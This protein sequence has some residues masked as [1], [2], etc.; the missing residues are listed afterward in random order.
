MNSL[1]DIFIQEDNLSIDNPEITN[2]TNLCL[3]N[4]PFLLKF[5]LRVEEITSE[6]NNN[7][8]QDLL[9]NHSSLLL[10]ELGKNKFNT[11]NLE[12]RMKNYVSINLKDNYDRLSTLNECQVLFMG[13]G[14][15]GKTSTIRSLFD[16]SFL[17]EDNSTL[18]L[19]D[20]DIFSVHPDSY[21]WNSISKYELSVQR[22]KNSLPHVVYVDFDPNQEVEA[23]YKLDFEEELLS[24]TVCDEKFIESMKKI[25]MVLLRMMFIFVFMIL[26]GKKYFLLFIIFL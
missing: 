12:G 2:L 16:K 11:K 9:D 21:N 25:V 26:V 10:F 3:K 6:E 8:V 15:V 24:R 1:V 20:I 5:V 22:V 19:N 17:L 7:E 13:D 23:K 14:R 18:V 4:L